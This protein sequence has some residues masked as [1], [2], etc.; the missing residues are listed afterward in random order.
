[1][2]TSFPKWILEYSSL[3]SEEP[4]VASETYMVFQQ[5]ALLKTRDY[6]Q[7]TLGFHGYSNW[8]CCRS[9]LNNFLTFINSWSLNRNIAVQTSILFLYLIRLL[10][11][12]LLFKPST[13]FKMLIRLETWIFV[14]ISIWDK[15][16]LHCRYVS[17]FLTLNEDLAFIK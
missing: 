13:P 17:D 9:S 7:N 2:K 14:I 5:N 8:D 4:C 3:S 10:Q 11:Q 15:K 12:S 6:F 1:M 16:L